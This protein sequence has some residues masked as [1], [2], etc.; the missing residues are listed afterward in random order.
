M[1]VEKI[2]ARIEEI[3]ADLEANVV[4]HKVDRDVLWAVD[5]CFH[6]V[7]QFKF[8]N[9]LVEKGVLEVLILGD[10]RIGKSQVAK[11]LTRHYRRGE[12]LQ[13][14]NVSLAGLFG[15]IDDMGDKNRF[16]KSGKL[17]LRHGELVVL[18]EANE[19]PHEVISKLSGVRSSG[20]YH[21]IKIVQAQIPCR[22]RL[23]W[24]ANPRSSQSIN[25]YS[26]GVESIPEVIGKP[27]DI[28][29]FDMAVVVSKQDVD[30]ESLYI[31]SSEKEV[32]PKVWS[33]ERCRALI[34][35]VWSRAPNQVSISTETETTIL[36]WAKTFSEKYHE[37]IPLVIESEQ[38]IKVSKLAVA[39]AA[40]VASCDESAET[41]VVLP[42]HVHVACRR[43]DEIYSRRS[44][45]Y[46]SWSHSQ[47]ARNL[48]PQVDSVI[49]ALGLEGIGAIMRQK[50]LNKTLLCDIFSDKDAGARGWSD[51][52]TGG[53]LRNAG[54]G[55]QPTE[56]LL[57][58]FRMEAEGGALKRRPN[59][60]L[61]NG[62]GS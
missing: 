22:L 8:Q 11:H 48:G 40:R 52:L 14:E 4:G 53:G 18:D 17:P 43:L 20:E 19:L 26:Y 13:A 32:I 21:L 58:R 56:S 41:I 36:D 45:G 24:I 9:M 59:A 12:L 29:R 28:A 15:G 49:E 51:L 38:R 35:W 10:T 42:E 25:E 44:M 55:Y 33:G 5:M 54:R 2:E 1:T 6:S 16:V 60:N 37:K 61:L 30:R 23:I 31:S 57:N 50:Y 27:E 39:V 47:R 62:G 34:D 7:F 3:H 46:D